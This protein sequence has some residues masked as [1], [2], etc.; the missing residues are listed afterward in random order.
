MK[1][2]QQA[3]ILADHIHTIY[4]PHLFGGFSAPLYRV[5]KRQRDLYP[6]APFPEAALYRALKQRERG[7]DERSF[8]G[9]SPQKLQKNSYPRPRAGVGGGLGTNYH[10]CGGFWLKKNALPPTCG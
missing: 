3:L 5:S 7:A 10:S 2:S 1:G 9:G 6:P 4:Y 8:W